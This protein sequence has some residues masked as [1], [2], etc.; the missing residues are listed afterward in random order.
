MRPCPD[1]VGQNKP[2]H[3][4]IFA[5]YSGLAKSLVHTLKFDCT[6]LAAIEMAELMDGCLPYF[7]NPPLVGYVPTAPAR[8]RARGFDH[9]QLVA[10]ELARLRGWHYT[11]FLARRKHNRQLG[12]DR[13]QRK[14][15]LKDTFR[16]VNHSLVKN[17]HILL[18]DDVVTTGATLEVCT[19]ELKKA[20][21]AQIDAAV[22]ARTPKNS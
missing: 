14:R 6:R 8:H 2:Q 10:K 1:C 22:F 18:V 20:G 3:V 4:W 17:R 9:A 5:E 11:T 21:A 7:A 16:I 19:K 15:Q 13:E 12:A